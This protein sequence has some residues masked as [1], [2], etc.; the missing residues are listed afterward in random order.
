MET[1]EIGFWNRLRKK[2]LYLAPFSEIM[3]GILGVLL[4]VLSIIIAIEIYEYQKKQ[5]T[6][7]SDLS[8]IVSVNS[9]LSLLK[10]KEINCKTGSFDLDI[11]TIAE[12]AMEKY[13]KNDDAYKQF[14]R[15]KYIQ[16]CYMNGMSEGFQDPRS[17]EL[18]QSLLK[19]AEKSYNDKHYSSSAFYYKLALIQVHGEGFP[20]QPKLKDAEDKIETNPKKASEL[21]E[22]SYNKVK[23]YLLYISW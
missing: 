6:L 13:I 1:E 2:A 3:I 21:F 20:N 14:I 5:D 22:E 17:A 12:R 11:I 16:P 9:I 10:D 7:N 15:N 19:A 18:N 23:M 8:S 4:T